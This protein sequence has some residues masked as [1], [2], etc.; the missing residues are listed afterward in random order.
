MTKCVCGCVCRPLFFV[1]STS[2]GF[3][4]F[5]QTGSWRRNKKP[6][7]QHKDTKALANQRLWDLMEMPQSTE[8]GRREMQG[9][10][11]GLGDLRTLDDFIEFTGVSVHLFDVSYAKPLRPEYMHVAGV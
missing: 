3:A 10:P 6:L 5:F 4:H 11:W 7:G 2:F 8:D 1:S 9:G